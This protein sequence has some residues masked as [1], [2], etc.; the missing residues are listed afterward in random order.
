MG[1]HFTLRDATTCRLFLWV[2]QIMVEGFPLEMTMTISAGKQAKPTTLL[3]VSL[4]SSTTW[5]FR[6]TLNQHVTITLTEKQSGVVK[7]IK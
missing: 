3:L 5:R 1:E 7:V 6:V 2:N 4:I